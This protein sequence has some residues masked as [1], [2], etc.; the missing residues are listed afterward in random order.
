V[1]RI[2]EEDE[3]GNGSVKMYVD[4]SDQDPAWYIE[5][6]PVSGDKITLAC[7]DSHDAES[8]YSQLTCNVQNIY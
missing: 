4:A 1:R 3:I 2:L 6:I 7:S 5:I 8:V